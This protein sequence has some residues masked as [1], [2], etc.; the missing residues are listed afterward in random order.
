M[1]TSGERKE[2]WVGLPPP[3][4]EQIE[5]EVV[6]CT[7]AIV[8]FKK[9]NGRPGARWKVGTT[10]DI[11]KEMQNLE[12]PKI[13]YGQEGWHTGVAQRAA[14]EVVEYHGMEIEGTLRVDD[15]GIYVY[16]DRAP[17]KLER[18]RRE[19]DPLTVKQKRVFRAI[20]EYVERNGR[21]PTKTEL[22]RI[23]GHKSATTTN[24]FLSILERKNWI[25]VEG[26][27]RRVELL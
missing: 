19:R 5:E 16:T 17:T 24:G 12:S 1:K 21:G 18:R 7:R 9:R 8:E 22:M 20:K 25:T 2:K 11:V 4:E 13:G 10:N 3:T 15:V 27:R 26:N 14:T 23:V 6:F